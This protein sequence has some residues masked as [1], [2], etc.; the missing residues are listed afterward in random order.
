MSTKFKCC[1]P[2]AEKHSSPNHINVTRCGNDSVQ[3]V[4]TKGGLL[5]FCVKH[6]HYASSLENAKEITREEFLVARFYLE[7]T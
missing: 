3:F 7:E 2:V 1:Y 5:S 6:L 4:Q